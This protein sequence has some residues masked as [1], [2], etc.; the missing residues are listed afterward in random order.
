[1]LINL[2]VKLVFLIFELKGNVAKVW[3]FGRWVK[4]IGEAR[5]F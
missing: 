3:T 5:Y 4:M 1:M 2:Y